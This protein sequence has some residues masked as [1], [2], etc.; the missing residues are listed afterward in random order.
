MI[1]LARLLQL[2]GLAIPP[3]AIIAQLSDAITLG[4]MLGFLVM[5]VAIFGV[6]YLM[7]RYSGGG[8]S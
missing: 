3:L 8:Q 7:Q 5:S 4:Q 2:I 6:G 1:G